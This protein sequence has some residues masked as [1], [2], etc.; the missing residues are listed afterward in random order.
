MGDF[1]IA[2]SL[3][4][5]HTDDYAVKELLGRGKFGAVH[6]VIDKKGGQ[7]AMKF[8]DKKKL[9]RFGVKGDKLNL[10]ITIMKTLSDS[11]Y[12]MHHLATYETRNDVMIV[13]ELVTGGELFHRIAEKDFFSEAETIHAVRQILA[14]VGE[15][16]A[17]RIIHRDLKPENIMVEG[18]MTTIK[19]IDFGLAVIKAPGSKPI[20]E[21]VGTPEYMAPEVIGYED[22]PFAADIWAVGCITYNLLA[23]V[24][25]FSGDTDLQTMGLVT[26]Y[27]G[28][29]DWEGDFVE[30]APPQARAFIEALLQKDPRKRPRADE[31]LK[32]P[33]LD[34][35]TGDAPESKSVINVAKL[36]QFNAQRRWKRAIKFVLSAVRLLRSIGARSEPNSPPRT[37][38]LSQSP[39]PTSF[40]LNP[41]TFETPTPSNIPTSISPAAKNENTPPTI[42]PIPVPTQSPTRERSPALRK[43]LSSRAHDP[44]SDTVVGKKIATLRD[45]VE[46]LEAAIEKEEK[47][48]GSIENLR[49]L[50]TA[51]EKNRL[52][53]DTLLALYGDW[54]PQARAP[55]QLNTP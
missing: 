19:L 33:W 17:R 22:T 12:F 18:D 39:R 3:R 2:D 36:R 43:P 6:R 30:P 52:R 14:G 41:P 23:G 25:P 9:A 42:T 35:A 15:M 53:L 4:T 1:V 51:L 50:D 26:A 49:K 20:Q 29:L 10:E 11:P 31:C 37:P 24:P 13:S 5:P 32:L 44:P 16:H 46:A 7:A 40:S 38:R 34:Q 27:S 47:A 28:N 21:I 48:G 8:L 54:T 55:G 45:T